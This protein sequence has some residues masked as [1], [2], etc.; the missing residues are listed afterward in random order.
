MTQGAARQLLR[1]RRQAGQIIS[2]MGE[3]DTVTVSA[4]G[5]R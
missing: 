1:L 3:N 4:C 2:V 5:L